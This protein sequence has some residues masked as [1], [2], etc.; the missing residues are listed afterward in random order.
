VIELLRL[1]PRDKIKRAGRGTPLPLPALATTTDSLGESP[2]MTA[3]KST[4]SPA[5]RKPRRCAGCRQALPA[6]LHPNARFCCATCPAS[7][8]PMVPAKP[9]PAPEPEPAVEAEPGPEN[10]VFLRPPQHVAKFVGEE[11]FK[12]VER[13]CGRCRRTFVPMA[14]SPDARFCGRACQNATVP[15]QEKLTRIP[16]LTTGMVGA[17]QELLVSADLLARG[18]HVFRA[19]SPSC[20]CDLIAMHRARLLRIEVRTGYR[21]ARGQVVFSSSS[22]D[23]DAAGASKFDV[24]AVVLPDRSIVYRPDH[25]PDR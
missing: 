4:S 22:R 20:P 15:A 12:V 3:R 6:G 21:G 9:K 19:V 25:F 18:I 11:R 1:S 13:R 17:V 8:L 23:L 2:A 7:P 5:R 24:I 16:G 10:S 14:K